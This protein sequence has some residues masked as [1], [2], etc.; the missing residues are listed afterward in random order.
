MRAL[1]VTRHDNVTS[2]VSAYKQMKVDI[3][4]ETPKKPL[5]HHMNTFNHYLFTRS[6]CRLRRPTCQGCTQNHK[7][8]RIKYTNYP[9]SLKCCKIHLKQLQT[10]FDLDTNHFQLVA[11]PCG[12]VAGLRNMAQLP[13]QHLFCH[14]SQALSFC[15]YQAYQF[16]HVKIVKTIRN[17]FLSKCTSLL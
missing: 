16:Q 6:T 4:R 5:R 8:D 15:N 10:S 9:I 3:E 11:L 7:I 2:I 12:G 14:Q 13:Y 17:K 1:K